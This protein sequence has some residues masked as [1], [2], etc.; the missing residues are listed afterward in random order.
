MPSEAVR[1]NLK[2]AAAVW[3]RAYQLSQLRVLPEAAEG[4][5]G[6]AAQGWQRASQGRANQSFSKKIRK[7][8]E[9]QFLQG[10]VSC[11]KI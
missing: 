6:P 11:I 7:R 5:V 8:P 2:E 10:M 9:S 4:C 1:G 3:A